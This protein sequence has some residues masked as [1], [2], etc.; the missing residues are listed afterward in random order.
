MQT[1]SSFLSLTSG[2]ITILNYILNYYP[3]VE[4]E[5]RDPRG[6][7]ALIKAGLQ[8][9]E[10]CVTALLMHGADMH[11]VDLVQGR[12]LKDWILRTGRFETLNRIR[13]LQ[14]HPVAGQFCESY[15]PE[16]PELKQLVEKA[17]APKSTSQKLRQRFKESLSFSFPHDPEENGVM[18]HMV[19]ITTSI[20]S[21]LVVTGSRPLCPTSPPEIGK[22]RYAVP[23]LLEK[24]SSKDPK[25]AKN[26]LLILQLDNRCESFQLV[27]A[28]VSQT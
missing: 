23:E 25:S 20:H 11:A 17:T 12:G 16:W 22:R 2:F 14:A 26:N 13:R 10:D 24:H 21:P 27:S 28:A 1:K 3:G 7:T 6:F 8:G 15:K 19:R 4:T 5:L 9:R 18:D